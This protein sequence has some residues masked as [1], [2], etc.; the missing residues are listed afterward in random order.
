MLQ[1][2]KQ[3]IT[4]NETKLLAEEVRRRAKRHVK[5]LGQASLGKGSDSGKGEGEVRQRKLS[6]KA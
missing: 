6:R 1:T 2:S 4:E 3:E 5:K